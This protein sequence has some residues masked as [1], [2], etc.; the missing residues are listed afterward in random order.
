MSQTVVLDACALI[1][2]IGN[3]SGASVVEAAIRDSQKTGTP[4]IMSKVNL[5]EVYYDSYRSY[6]KN[7]ADNLVK[8]IKQSP[9]RIISSLSDDVL[10]EAGRLKVNY[11]V[12]LAD[13]IAL[14]ETS[15][16][17]GVLMTADHHEFDII[18]QSE[19]ISFHWIR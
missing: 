3:E 2:L 13:S 18:E 9:I 6:G 14:A 10:A 1:A 11:K 16:S 8:T 12:S 7:V 19:N 15:I 4:L 5:L 17:K